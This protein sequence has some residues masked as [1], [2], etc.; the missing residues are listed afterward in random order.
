MRILCFDGLSGASGDMFVGALLGAGADFRFVE[1]SVNALGVE[2]LCV[3]Y[4]KVLKNSLEATSF[5]VTFNSSGLLADEDPGS[6]H[7]HRGLSE[8]L[9]ILGAASLDEEVIVH[10]EAV[11]SILA[12][13]E[14]AVH[15][16]SPEKIHFHE[17]GALDS[18]ADVV[19]ASAAFVSIGAKKAFTAPPVLGSGLIR[20]AHGLL[21]APA[22][23]VLEI[24]KNRPVIIDPPTARGAGELT[25]PTGAAL[26]RHFCTEF[27]LPSG[28][29][30]VG[31]G[32]G[33]G[34]KDFDFPNVLRAVVG[35]L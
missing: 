8:I 28:F 17:V 25:T 31:V 2:G 18:I 30:V 5:R 29:S 26:L 33:A 32:Y 12:E 20:C 4:E 34:K 6:P 24:L 27:S 14:G 23:A 19:A 7:P 13:A 11:F 1:S 21:P 3:S 10:A 15:G 9:S 16:V 22:P 35:E